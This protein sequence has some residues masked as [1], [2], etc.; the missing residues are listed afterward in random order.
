MSPSSLS[1]WSP[2]Y[3]TGA[4]SHPLTT[5]KRQRPNLC[6]PRMGAATQTGRAKRLHRLR[7]LLAATFRESS[8]AARALAPQARRVAP[9]TCRMVAWVVV[10][11]LRLLHL[12][13]AHAATPTAHVRPPVTA[14]RSSQREVIA[15]ISRPAGCALPN[16][17]GASIQ[18]PFDRPRRS[19]ATSAPMIVRRDVVLQ[20]D[21]VRGGRA[22]HDAVPVTEDLG[23]SACAGG[24]RARTPRGGAPT[25]RRG[26]RSMRCIR[27]FASSR[28]ARPH[29]S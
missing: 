19:L 4:Q 21:D 20:G 6:R 3:P 15:R 27:T 26:A 22:L 9:P 23:V 7:R 28:S 5:R 10:A 29:R 18:R 13:P 25:R 12:H 11:R 8:T 14:R 2:S 16:A 17:V 24:G 1:A